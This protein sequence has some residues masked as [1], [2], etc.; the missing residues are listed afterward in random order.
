MSIK[1]KKDERIKLM[2]END[3]TRIIQFNPAHQ[4]E[5][6]AIFRLPQNR[7][8]V[9]LHS[10]RNAAAPGEQE[11]IA[12]YVEEQNK[13]G[14]GVY[15]PKIHNFQEDKTGGIAICN[16]MRYVISHCGQVAIGYNPES[17]GTKFD[18]GMALFLDRPIVLLNPELDISEPTYDSMKAFDAICAKRKDDPSFKSDKFIEFLS[19]TRSI[20]SETLLHDT[21]PVLLEYAHRPG[22]D[23][24]PQPPSLAP[25]SAI[26]LGMAYASQKPFRILNLDDAKGQAHLEDKLGYFKSYSKVAL[27]L[28]DIY[29][30]LGKF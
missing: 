9:L 25:Y 14:N 18:Y 29:K 12:K 27:K 2:S 6:E 26:E 30:G 16:T 21:V 23:G 7:R 20:I 1:N 8:I 24:K 28:H 17:E 11:S 4:D 19:I 3:L 13:Q 5:I 15:I 22:K 10:V